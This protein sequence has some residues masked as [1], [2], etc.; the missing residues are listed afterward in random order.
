MD[1]VWAHL[2]IPPIGALAVAISSAVL[3][4]ILVLVFRYLGQQLLAGLS[5]FSLAV[6]TLL[7]AIS[8]RAALGDYPTLGGAT[9]AVTTLLVLERLFGAWTTLRP[10]RRPPRRSPTLLM[11]G[12]ELRPDEM[13][14]HRMTQ[15]QLWSALRQSGLTSRS[16]VAL[17]VLETRGRLTVIRRG[18]PI[19]PVLLRGVRGVDLVP[20]EWLEQT[21]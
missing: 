6:T 18:Q 3:Y 5:T 21:P 13:R 12:P 20:S 1:D 8:A 14:R 11:I 2:G 15:T 19:D 9:V 4:L 17:V 10:S 7:G 16:Q